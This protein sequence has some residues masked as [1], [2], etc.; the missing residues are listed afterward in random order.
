[1]SE[2]MLVWNRKKEE[3]DAVEREVL[4]HDKHIVIACQEEDDF[5][6]GRNGRCIW[7]HCKKLPQKHYVPFENADI[8]EEWH[9]WKVRRKGDAEERRIF[10]YDSSSYSRNW[11]L[12]SCWYSSQEAFGEFDLWTPERGWDVFGKE[13][14]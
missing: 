10:A 11:F 12:F 3:K 5:S 14:E 7:A 13:V 6:I 2:R 4:Y 8:P 1:M 9:L